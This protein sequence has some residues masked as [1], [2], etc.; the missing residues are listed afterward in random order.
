MGLI[1]VSTHWLLSSFFSQKT[2]NHIFIVVAVIQD[3]K[4]D[5]PFAVGDALSGHNLIAFGSTI[6]S[7]DGI[8]NLAKFG[9][10][11]VLMIKGEGELLDGL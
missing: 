9:V 6:N 3:T 1:N 7:S 4:A 5:L 10:L 2:N 8:F 11:R